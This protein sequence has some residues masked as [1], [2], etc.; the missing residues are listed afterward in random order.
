MR[1][2]ESGKRLHTVKLMEP[3]FLLDYCNESSADII[4]GS[5]FIPYS[6]KELNEVDLVEF[7]ALQALKMIKYVT[8]VQRHC[9]PVDV[10]FWTI[11]NTDNAHAVESNPNKKLVNGQ[12]Y[13]ECLYYREAASYGPTY[14]LMTIVAEL[15]WSAGRASRF[16]TPMVYAYLRSLNGHQTNWAKAILH[17][18]RMEISSLQNRGKTRENQKTRAIMWAPVLLQVV[19]AFRS[20]IFAG[21]PLQEADTWLRW[22]H[23]T[24]D[25]DMTLSSLVARFQDP[26]INL[27]DV[28]ENCLLLEQIP[29]A[30]PV[31]CTEIQPYRKGYCRTKITVKRKRV[32]NEPPRENVLEKTSQLQVQENSEPGEKYV[33]PVLDVRTVCEGDHFVKTSTSCSPPA[34]LQQL[35]QLLGSE[36]AD[37]VILKCKDFWREVQEE[38]GNAG[39]WKR[40]H[41]DLLRANGEFT[42]RLAE[43]DKNFLAKEVEWKNTLAAL[44]DELTSVRVADSLA[45]EDFRKQLLILE[46]NLKEKTAQLQEEQ[47]SKE[48]LQEQY[49]FMSE[50]LREKQESLLDTRAEATEVK[51]RMTTLECSILRL[52]D[53]LRCKE[54]L[55]TEAQR[56]I[57]TLKT[58][59]RPVVEALK[60]KLSS[61][62]AELSAKTLAWQ[63]YKNA[64]DSLNSQLIV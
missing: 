10:F 27:Q 19:Y 49:N 15:F 6:F 23:M 50:Q 28:R 8:A 13:E 21:T 35:G 44:R 4:R 53:E 52:E 5:Q 48:W 33:T 1:P 59:S 2:E 45:S 31:N 42:S 56:E 64:L 34:N 36:V 12:R 16:L 39:N 46:E 25:G 57:E 32:Q 9:I 24:K 47:S 17:S 38:A 26:I 37:L 30:T 60:D 22:S 40:K 7:S 63:K 54:S 43:K 55:L 18:L 58:E 3:K 29:L 41:D 11:F 20:T 62:E 61:L 51:V 14:Y